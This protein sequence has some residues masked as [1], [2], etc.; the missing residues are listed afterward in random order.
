MS[1]TLLQISTRQN[2]TSLAQQNDTSLTKQNEASLTRQ[3]ETSL[4]RQKE[5]ILAQ[6]NDTNGAR[7]NDT[8]LAL[9]QDGTSGDNQQRYL[10]V[11]SQ[12]VKIL[13]KYLWII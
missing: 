8:K 3:N 5:T 11:Q 2:K 6:Q 9:I 10:P 13:N 7:Q 1:K 4:T 12:L